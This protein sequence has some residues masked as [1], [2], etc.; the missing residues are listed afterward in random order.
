MPD[1][2]DNILKNAVNLLND[3]KLVAFPTETVYGLG[4]DASNLQAVEAVFKAKGRPQNHPLI[5][6]LSNMLA[7]SE[8]AR[9]VPDLAW[10]LAE[11]FWP[12]PL[13]LVLPKH[14]RVLPAVTGGQDTVALRVPNHPITLKLLTLFGGGLVGPSANRFGRISP[15]SATDV[16]EELGDKVSLILDG[17]RCSVGLESTIVYVTNEYIQILRRGMIHEEVIA[18]KISVPILLDQT[19][20]IIT[21]GM[22][23]SH[24]AP[25]NRV[26][27]VLSKYFNNYI[28]KLIKLDKTPSVLSFMPKPEGFNILWH[29]VNLDFTEYAR[30]L[31]SNLRHLD[32]SG[33]TDIVVELPPNQIHWAAI[34]DRL[35]RAAA[36]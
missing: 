14:T 10:Q 13:T 27:L 36:C 16:E 33:C 5:I 2:Q 25:L 4:A 7:M 34:L 6:H 30:N 15:T 18:S 1:N 28:D 9:D 12:G 26:H 11:T 3:G 20:A 24:Y 22:S 29:Q 21:P 19:Q 32:K 17:G 23:V 35:K 31:Y 8:W